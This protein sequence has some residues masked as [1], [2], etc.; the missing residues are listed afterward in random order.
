MNWNDKISKIN[1]KPCISYSGAETNRR[2]K[3]ENKTPNIIT[4]FLSVS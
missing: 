2:V 3:Q 1:G 4:R